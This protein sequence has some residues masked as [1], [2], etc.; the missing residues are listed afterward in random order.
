MAS[1]SK[2]DYE[3]RGMSFQEFDGVERTVYSGGYEV[4]ADGTDYDFGASYQ[5]G[6]RE[7]SEDS[8][9][10]GN[11]K[12]TVFFLTASIRKNMN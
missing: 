6:S 5:S 2:N 12:L 4:K 3:L 9:G 7:V 1:R 10:Y 11:Y 8:R